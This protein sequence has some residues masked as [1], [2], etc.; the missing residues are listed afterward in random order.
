MGSHLMSISSLNT[1]IK[2][3]LEATFMHVMV[4]GEIAQVTYAASGHVYFTLKDDRDTLKCVLWRSAVSRLKFRLEQGEHV[5]VEGSISVYTPRGEYQLIG[6]HVE[7][8]GQGALAVAFAQRKADLQAKGYFDPAIKKTLPRY[9]DRIIL[10]TAATGAALQDMLKIARRR[11]PVVD[12][13]VIDVLVQGEQAS[14][15]IARAITYADALGADILIVGRGGGS[16]EDLWAFNE[17]VVAEAIHVARTPVVSAVGHEVD[18]LISDMVADVRAPTPSAAMEIVLPDRDEMLRILDERMEQ[19]HLRERHI[20]AQKTE[21]LANLRARFAPLSPRLRLAGMAERFASLQEDFARAIHRNIE[22]NAAQ[23][24]P[25]GAHLI[26]AMRV[27]IQQKQQA[28]DAVAQRLKM[29]DPSQRV[30]A[31]YAE[32]VRGGKRTDLGD[33]QIGDAFELVNREVSIAARATGKR[34]RNTTH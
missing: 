28:C 26:H 30:H 16:S 21:A 12:I 27:L 4:E 22:Q 11:W 34:K 23:L 6:T 24:K 2:S 3:L 14:G 7:P 19:L 13:T 1:K 9:P 32:I 5:V 10:I 17:A 29:S 8:Y 31:G 15:E 18:I 25:S 33:I 20:F